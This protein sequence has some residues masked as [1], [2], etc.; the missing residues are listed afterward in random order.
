MKE[1]YVAESV[2]GL[3][4]LKTDKYNYTSQNYVQN[5]PSK[6]VSFYSTTYT[7]KK[8]KNSGNRDNGSKCSNN[9]EMQLYKHNSKQISRIF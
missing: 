3:S 6:E 1:F 9:Q 7:W 8:N 2:N 5:D 4:S